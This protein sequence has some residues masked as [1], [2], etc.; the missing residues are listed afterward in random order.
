MPYL[1]IYPLKLLRTNVQITT[2]PIKKPG[3]WAI[4][5]PLSFCTGFG[6]M[7][8][9]GSI[10][11]KSRKWYYWLCQLGGWGVFILINTFYYYALGLPEELYPHYFKTM[12]FMAFAGLAVT[13]VMRSV[14]LGINVLSFPLR[15]QILWFLIITVSFSLINTIITVSTEEINEW[16]PLLY[17]D[18]TFQEKLL[19]DSF[20]TLLYFT[21]WNLL[22]FVYH[23]IM[24]LQK[25]L[26][27]EAQLETLV[28]ELELKTIKAHI[29][30]HFIFNA[31]NSIRAL[32]E[33]NPEKARTAITTLSQLLRNS[34]NSEKEDQVTLEQELTM[35]ENYLHLEKIRFEDR[36]RVKKNID[37]DTLGQKVPHMML[38]TLV[39]NAIKHGISKEVKGGEIEIIS[40]FINNHH[41]IIV[42]NTGRL[43][44]HLHKSGFGLSS[45]QNRLELLYAKKAKFEIKELGNHTVEAKVILPVNTL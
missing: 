44:G 35:V 42:R 16:E 6:P 25:Q 30:P 39:E 15:K 19:K 43:N 26:I 18:F 37:P 9:P 36:L 41:E 12:Y 22:Y 3:A 8:T 10:F 4:L 31:L 45:T 17:R 38:Q 13:H 1:A 23:Y 11:F 14:I 21:I 29:N 27:T 32:V 5:L 7:H 33:E 28:K 40:D 34:L 2:E 20:G 24:S